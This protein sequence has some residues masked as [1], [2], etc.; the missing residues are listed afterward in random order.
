M[1]D[2]MVWQPN[3]E[4]EGDQLAAL[5]E[6][7]GEAAAPK[8]T[9]AQ[10]QQIVANA[11]EQKDIDQLFALQAKMADLIKQL[12]ANGK[13]QPAD[14]SEDKLAE[15]LDEYLNLREL[16]AV[17]K[18]RY[19]MIRT[20]IFA[21]ITD[22]LAANNV[23]DP[24]HSP[25]EL[26]IPQRGMKFARQGGRRK[27]TLDKAALADKLGPKRWERVC[28]A[29]VVPAV[30]E[31]EEE[32]FDQDALFELVAEDPSVM[33]LIRECAVVGGYTPSSLHVKELKK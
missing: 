13:L 8:L 16:E 33:E 29:V 22:K 14:L 24:E 3:E 28:K 5:L 30:P 6:E 18:V 7:V 27:V 11:I 31:H 12:A 15:V 10:R 1:T 17:Y 20:L 23:T 32:Q 9:V 26:P 4:L 19:Q 21:A 2:Q 25:G